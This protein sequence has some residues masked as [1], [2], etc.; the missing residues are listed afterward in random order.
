MPMRTDEQLLE[1]WSLGRGEDA[2]LE[3]QE[4]R[5]LNMSE[6]WMPREDS[7]LD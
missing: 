3:R 6:R 5:V 4:L 7:N 1:G 2:Q